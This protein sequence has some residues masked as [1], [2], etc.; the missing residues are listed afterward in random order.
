MKNMREN[1]IIILEHGKYER[2]REIE[3]QREKGTAY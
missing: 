3:R 2:A 1:K